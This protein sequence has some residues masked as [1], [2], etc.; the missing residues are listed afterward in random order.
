MIGV[1][2]DALE[3]RNGQVIRNGEEIDEPYIT[4][5]SF[6]SEPETLIPAGHYYVMGDNRRGS[7]DSRDWGLLPE[8]DIIGRA[9]FRYWPPSRMGDA[10]GVWGR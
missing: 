10:D 6:A 3:I 4:N 2:G 8:S 5:H 7:N 1:P 9:W